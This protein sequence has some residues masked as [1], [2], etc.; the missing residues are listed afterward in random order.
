MNT[1]FNSYSIQFIG[2]VL[3]QILVLN[4][5]LFL[6]YINPYAYILCFALFPV[7]HSRALLLILSFVLGLCIDISSDSGGIHAAACVFTAY[8]RPLILRFAFGSLYL[9]QT[10][11]FTAVTLATLVIY[12]SIITVIHHT[13]LFFLETFN[14]N[15]IVLVFKKIVFSSIF[16]ILISTLTFIIFSKRDS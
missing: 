15:N 4:H 6:G 1:V 5:V 9:H 3:V 12:L 7:K 11:K 10:I 2:L 14:T 8:V 16:T 13:V